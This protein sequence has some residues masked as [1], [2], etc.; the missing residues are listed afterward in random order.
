ST[1]LFAQDVR[2]PS[3]FVVVNHGRPAGEM[4]VDVRGDSTTVQFRYQDRQRG[5]SVQVQLTTD[6]ARGAERTLTVN[7]M[8]SEF[9]ATDRRERFERDAAR[10]RWIVGAD[11]ESVATV[12]SP[13]YL[14]N[15]RTP[16]EMA[17]L[18]RHLLTQA[19]TTMPLLP[20][21]RARAA[22]SAETTLVVDGRSTR[23]RFVTI[24]VFEGAPS[25]VWLDE[26]DALVADDAGWFITVRAGNE[27]ILPALRAAETRWRE[28]Q[29]SAIAARLHANMAGTVAIT[30]GTLFDS[31]RGTA[32]PRMSV[33]VRDGRI[34]AVGPADSVRAPTGATIIDA[35][36]KTIIPGMWDMHTH[37]GLGS[38][39]DGALRQLAAGITTVRDM[40][41]DIDV[42]L[43]RRARADAGT[44][45]SPRV[46]LAGFIEGP[47]AWAGP[48]E[49]LVRTEAEARAWVARYDSLGYRQIKLY[50]LVHPDLVPTIAAEARKRGLR[51]S[52]HIPRGLTIASAVE[53][54]FDEFQHAA[55]LISSLYPDS[56]FVPR[57]RAYSNFAAEMA[58]TFD[59]N[60]PQVT[61]L[62]QLL[63][64]KGTVV[65]GTFN[66]YES[67]M[68]PLRSGLHP[69]L[70]PSLAWL[71]PISRRVFAYPSG[72]SATDR[73]RSHALT[74]TYARYLKRLYDAG[75]T[76]VPGTDNIEGLSYHGELEIYERAGIPAAAVLQMATI[77]SA[78]VMGDSAQYGSVAVGKVADIAIVA[79]KPY[80]QITDLRRTETVLRA[81]RVYRSKELY[82]LTGMVVP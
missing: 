22:V 18:A 31:E 60:T 51:L 41:A 48:S 20:V 32:R 70:G 19:G 68:D 80:E 78:R 75:I 69:V 61:A 44:I 17:L 1:A 65:D 73:A 33:V 39:V 56:L 79:G 59:V 34:I 14:S 13:F 58:P 24:D 26:R 54:G 57:M 12:G 43:S 45:A 11:T 40:A 35:T 27:G 9:I 77:V 6:G 10:T 67:G 42:A 53:L 25:G 46:V 2:A 52:G 71:P 23:L 82:Q 47:G 72:V 63:R 21:G 50:N 30:N 5:P 74:A 16:Y 8:T 55:F 36:G 76:L 37:L 15:A 81:G 3:R 7:G 64:R 49:V 62:L 38:E 29:A 66:V 28:A 4:R